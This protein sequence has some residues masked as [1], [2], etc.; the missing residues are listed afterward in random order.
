MAVIQRA[1]DEQLQALARHDPT[2]MR[3]TA[4]ADYYTVLVQGQRNMENGG[5]TAIKLLTLQ[6][7]AISV[8]GTNAQ[9][10]TVETWQ[11]SFADSSTQ[12]SS[13]R[14]VYAL[15]QQSGG[16][17]IASDAHPDSHLNQ[18][19]PGPN[20]GA[21]APTPPSGAAGA[22]SGANQSRNWA[23]YA[24]SGG[25][26]TTVSGS[27]TVPQVNVSGTA[28]GADATWVGIGGVVTHDL[29]QAGTQATV[30]GPGQVEYSAW[31]ETLP[32]P[33]QTVP[34]VV[35]PGDMVNV[36]I[37]QQAGV[38]WQ[39]SIVNQTTSQRFQTTVQYQ[40]SL[41]SVEWIEEAPATGGGGAHIVTLDNFGSVQVKGGSA[42]KGGQQVTIAQA[43]GQPITMYGRTG[44]PIAGTSALG[45]DSASFTVTR[46]SGGGPLATS[47]PGR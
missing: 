23:G 22:G 7:G 39:I 26:F 20:P 13:D 44:Q 10:T 33:S 16:W 37:T 3:D 11:T 35:S 30:F 18:P 31:M 8:Q 42:V 21:S 34:L 29:I 6:W 47:Q 46:L 4:T 24:A 25:P 17:L 45:A 43:G 5:V 28:G 1:N 38:T 41:S 15:V 40:S 27:W 14:N 32:D 2:L 9:A 12:Q 36:S 19:G